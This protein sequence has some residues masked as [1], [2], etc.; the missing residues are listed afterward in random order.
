MAILGL[1]HM[2]NSFIL[3]ILI[4]SSPQISAE[5]MKKQIWH[6]DSKDYQTYSVNSYDSNYQAVMRK[7]HSKGDSPAHI[8]FR[9][10]MEQ[11]FCNDKGDDFNTTSI[12]EVNSQ[13]VEFSL[14]CSDGRLMNIVPLNRRGKYYILEEFEQ[15]ILKN[16]TFVWA[17]EG[18][19]D[20]IFNFSTEG[21]KNYYRSIRKSTKKP[22]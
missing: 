22:I 4:I 13:E 16:V 12:I 6:R 8:D 9:L 10:I 11:S 18:E 3:S 7:I 19:N 21:F 14:G 1:I 17:K 20:L 2:K 15:Y 5:E